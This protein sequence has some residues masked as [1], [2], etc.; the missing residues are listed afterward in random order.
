MEFRIFDGFEMKLP[1]KSSTIAAIVLILTLIM[2][3]FTAMQDWID[4]LR[5]YYDVQ[6]IA[7]LREHCC[8]A[9]D[10]AIST[11]GIMIW[12]AT[13]ALA[14]FCA[15]LFSASRARPERNFAIHVGALSAW[16][17]IDDA[18]LLHEIVLPSVGIPQLLV[19]ACIG[20]AL[21]ALLALHRSILAQAI[22]WLLAVSIVL[23]SISAL[24]DIVFPGVRSTLL[25]VEDGSKLIGVVA[26]CLFFVDT[27]FKL[28]MQPVITRSRQ[29]EDTAR[30][31]R[32]KGTQ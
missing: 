12:A 3:I 15:L 18:Y 22:W 32:A 24:V 13:S 6:T 17:A 5:L 11:L 23:F 28:L 10:G 30:K 25:V 16:L 8:S 21:I 9:Y 31:H 2:V 20:F 1:S 14:F 4:P 7:Q 29:A 27:F 19:L 26:W